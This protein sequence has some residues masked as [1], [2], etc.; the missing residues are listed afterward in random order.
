MSEGGV[1]V[2]ADLSSCPGGGWWYL[3]WEEIKEEGGGFT[4]HVCV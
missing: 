4:I 2:L 1:F 3:W